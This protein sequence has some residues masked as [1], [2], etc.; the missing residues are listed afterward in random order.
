MTA[1]PAFY[2]HTPRAL[3]GDGGWHGE[4]NRGCCE[5][6]RLHATEDAAITELRAVM[7]SLDGADDTQEQTTTPR[8]I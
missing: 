4:C 1:F 8:G 7:E 3:L 6:R 2:E 5:T